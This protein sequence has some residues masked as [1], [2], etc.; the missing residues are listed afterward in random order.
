MYKGFLVLTQ[1]E[2]KLINLMY[3]STFTFFIREYLRSTF[4]KA[5]MMKFRKFH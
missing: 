1:N 4:R 2:M 5:L 3:L